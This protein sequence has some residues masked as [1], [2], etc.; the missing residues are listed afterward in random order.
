MWNVHELM[1]WL[2]LCTEYANTIISFYT[3]YFTRIKINTSELLVNKHLWCHNLTLYWGCLHLYSM[4]H[5]LRININFRNLAEFPK[6]FLLLCHP[7]LS[8][9]L[10]LAVYDIVQHCFHCTFKNA[11]YV[12]SFYYH[13]AC[14][15]NLCTFLSFNYRH[16]TLATFGP[17]TPTEHGWPLQYPY[18]VLAMTPIIP[19]IHVPFP[20]LGVITANSQNKNFDHTKWITLHLEK[21]FKHTQYSCML[22]K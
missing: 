5:Q 9:Y 21:C 1:V 14:N 6:F 11:W 16:R 22:G 4:S 19:K 17:A 8:K 12:N 13:R 10:A 7:N 2:L 3:R 20:Y 18:R 15:I